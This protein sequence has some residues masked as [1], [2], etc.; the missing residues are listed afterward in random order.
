MPGPGVSWQINFSDYDPDDDP[1]LP[2]PIRKSGI[3]LQRNR[4]EGVSSSELC[5]ALLRE[6]LFCQGGK[7]VTFH[8]MYDVAYLLKILT[9]GKPL[10]DT[11]REFMTEAW[12]IFGG[13][14]FDIK[15][16][17]RF[18]PGLLGGELG[19]EKL[20]NLLKV[21][22]DGVAHQAGFDSL[23][24]GLI[25]HE[26]HKRWEIDDEQVSM[27][28]YGLESACQEIKAPSSFNPLLRSP[29]STGSGVMVPLPMM[30]SPCPFRSQRGGVCVHPLAT[31][32]MIKW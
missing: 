20:A 12:S 11:L 31:P 26:L 8:G 16:M 1:S 30:R 10:P 5:A 2:T 9:G 22:A 29:A 14:L 13:R 25:F 28:L 18:C 24:T 6:K 17:A 21:E 23:V 27:I 4:R 3:D 7:F 15:Y 19:L 32:Y